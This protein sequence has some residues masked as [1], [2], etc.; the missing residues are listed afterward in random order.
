MHG[1]MFHQ[2]QQNEHLLYLPHQIIEIKKTICANE[3][4]SIFVWTR[5]T[6]VA[7]LDQWMV[8]QLSY[9]L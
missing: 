6:N 9:F 3:N 4:P 1:Q 2:Y 5:H 8:V 7:M